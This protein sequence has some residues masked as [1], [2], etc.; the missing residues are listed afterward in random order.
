VSR[1]LG[2]IALAA[3]VAGCGPSFHTAK[4]VKF[5]AADVAPICEL[6]PKAP[7]SAVAARDAVLTKW[8]T[9]RDAEA[10]YRRELATF[11]TDLG[12][13]EPDES[14][15]VMT[16]EQ[17]LE[18]LTTRGCDVQGDYGKIAETTFKCELDPGAQSDADALAAIVRRHV[19]KL[20]AAKE[21]WPKPDFTFSK[22]LNT[23]K[24]ECDTSVYAPAPS[25]FD[26]H[27]SA[28]FSRASI[29]AI[30]NRCPGSPAVCKAECLE[31]AD[32]N[33]C[34][35]ASIDKGTPDADKSDLLMRACVL[36]FEKQKPASLC[37][38]A[39]GAL[40]K[41]STPELVTTFEK[42]VGERCSTPGD[43]CGWM[44]SGGAQI[45]SVRTAAT[46]T[47]AVGA[48]RGTCEASENLEACVS[49]LLSIDGATPSSL[50][51]ADRTA[52]GTL[53]RTRCA[54]GSAH[55]CEAIATTGAGADGPTARRDFAVRA[56]DLDAKRCWFAA[57]CFETGK[58]T[59]LAADPALSKHANARLCEDF[60]AK[61]KEATKDAKTDFGASYAPCQKSR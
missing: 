54:G 1:K 33:G 10:R 61:M 40:S 50:P 7:P 46:F 43:A 20:H 25:M 4:P 2:A 9:L 32:P 31:R 48:L 36:P 17:R 37:S 22:E 45:A 12:L 13:R 6:K 41:S 28:A 5:T 26:V 34:F 27:L 58:C 14:L 51:A 16:L 8:K 35:F 44:L 29:A 3:A 21:A 56:C 19:P 47:H 53:F 39:G 59:G 60:V 24:K 57:S 15:V 52:I 23:W 18:K 55:A 49:A 11:A 42:L 38:M 30:K